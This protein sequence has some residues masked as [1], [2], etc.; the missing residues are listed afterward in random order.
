MDIN[1]IAEKTGLLP[2]E[3]CSWVENDVPLS[4]RGVRVDWLYDFLRKVDRHLQDEWERFDNQARATLYFDYVPEPA[5]PQFIRDQEITP[6][7]LIPNLILPLTRKLKSPFYARIPLEHRGKPNLFV[8]HTWSQVLVS[9][10]A[11]TTLDPISSAMRNNKGGRNPY[12]WIDIVS[13]NQHLFENVASDMK[14]V[15]SSIGELC[16]PMIDAAPFSRL[17]CLWE[18]LCAHVTKSEI[19]I[20][21]PSASPYDIGYVYDVFTKDFR[22][23]SD[24]LTTLPK[25]KEEILNAMIATFGSIGGT[26]EYLC[27]VVEHGLTKQ[28]DKPWN[29]PRK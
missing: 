29:T 4:D 27:K 15:I 16:L 12:V 25:D 10:N 21:E 20:Y 5:T 22:S 26:D 8:S 6:A 14:A 23:V 7:F 19:N 11:F 18:M 24:A 2:E 1:A 28:S 9:G 17:W 13:Y 3:D